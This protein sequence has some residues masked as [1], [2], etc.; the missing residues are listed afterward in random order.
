MILR[1]S[2]GGFEFPR[3]DED[4]L[5]QVAALM[6]TMAG[7]LIYSVSSLLSVLHELTAFISHKTVESMELV[8]ESFD[9]LIPLLLFAIAHKSQR[10]FVSLLQIY[11]QARESSG[12]G[13]RS[14]SS[15]S[16]FYFTSNLAQ[17]TNT[18][19]YAP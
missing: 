8:V 11:S 19:K 6:V 16:Q 14:L 13:L 1:G 2:S 17:H 10:D 18:I 9:F 12:C 4:G 15:W 7:S 3:T 5:F